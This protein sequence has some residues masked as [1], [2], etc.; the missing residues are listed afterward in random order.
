MWL[1]S[2]A[3]GP[4]NGEVR[5][6]LCGR[7]MLVVH[8]C[9]K[10]LCPVQLALEFS[11][12]TNLVFI[13]LYFNSYFFFCRGVHTQLRE[14]LITEQLRW[15]CENGLRLRIF[16]TTQQS[17]YYII[18]RLN[19]SFFK[20]Q[21]HIWWDVRDQIST[22]VY[23]HDDSC[24]VSELFSN[25]THMLKTDPFQTSDLFCHHCGS[26]HYVQ[27]LDWDS[28]TLTPLFPIAMLLGHWL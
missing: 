28:A 5:L 15:V 20:A 2:L 22:S 19:P 6:L 14:H 8:Q 25:F 3:Q 26:Y 18:W 23:V 16:Q 27:I 24:P 17:C 13:Y 12:G 21:A 11:S 7:R 10:S 1:L 4:F 9:L